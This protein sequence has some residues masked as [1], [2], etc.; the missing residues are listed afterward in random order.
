M[1]MPP[2]DL[3][4]TEAEEVD[5]P[6]DEIKIAEVSKTFEKFIVWGHDSLP[7]A[8]SDPHIKG[9]QEWIAFAQK[10]GSTTLAQFSAHTKTRKPDAWSSHGI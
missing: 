10:V 3:G 2:A 1:D 9:V 7:D 8:T 4:D 6:P 5:D